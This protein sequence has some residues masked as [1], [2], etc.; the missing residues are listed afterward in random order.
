MF[1]IPARKL[2]VS[3]RMPSSGIWRRIDLVWTDF[4]E[5]RI[6]S[7]FRAEKSANE[8][9]VWAGGCR[10]S[11]P[12]HTGS[13]FADFS[14]LKMEV[15][16]SSETSV[17]TKYTRRHNP[18]DGILH[19]P[20]RENLKSYFVVNCDDPLSCQANGTTVPQ[21]MTH[22]NHFQFSFCWSSCYWTLCSLSYCRRHKT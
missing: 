22:P 15:I 6:A 3:W 19:S 1:Q 16:R 11:P 7:I 8:E 18:E 5:E 9:P 20:R 12:A 21:I 2:V 10:L 17:Y 13:S 14:A 4:S